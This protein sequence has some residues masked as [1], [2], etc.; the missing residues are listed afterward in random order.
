[1]V[2]KREQTQ[3]LNFFLFLTC[4]YTGSNGPFGVPQSLE[5]V[6][7]LL[8][9]SWLVF[10]WR[11][12]LLASGHRPFKGHKLS[13]YF[14]SF[15]CARFRTSN[16]PLSFL[17]TMSGSVFL[18]DDYC[19]L[20]LFIY[21]LNYLWTV[22]SGYNKRYV[23]CKYLSLHPYNERKCFGISEMLFA[24]GSWNFLEDKTYRRRILRTDIFVL[25][26]V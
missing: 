8:T 19:L 10:Y 2:R 12:H 13:T 26:V 4:L 15:M 11:L 25:L 14:R 16:F 23:V 22:Q 3:T 18:F 5:L 20:Y 17:I 7:V 21:S 1:M 24:R 6:N 9:S